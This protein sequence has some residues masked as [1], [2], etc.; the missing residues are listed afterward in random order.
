MNHHFRPSSLAGLLVTF[1]AMPALPVELRYP[2]GD[3]HGFPSMS[4]DKGNLI[5]DGELT[6]KQEGD[7][8][9]VHAVWRFKDG[10]VAEEDDVLLMRP[11][12][13][14]ES[15]LWV[16]RRGKDEL[17]RAEVDFRTGKASVSHRENGK[18]KTWDE[19]LDLPRGK[20][21]TGYSTALAASQLR[22]ALS[23]KDAR[24]TLTFVAFTPK[25]RTVELEISRA[26][27]SRIRAAGRELPAD[28]Y[29]LHPKIPFPLSIAAHAP[30][31]YLWFTHASP[32]GLLRAE[33]NL[34]EKDDPRIRIDVIPSGAALPRP[35]ARKGKLP[36]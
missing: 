36:R 31:S 16:E 12:L 18:R 10:R 3:L 26:P 8:L 17:R 25:P 27:G 35:A 34:L 19:K 28:R 29:T 20:A 32:P 24:R 15:F 23:D 7:R 6:Q 2:Q 21:F 11:E 5:A 1:A 30:D 9:L 33:Q 22:D 14:Q 4:D 13:S